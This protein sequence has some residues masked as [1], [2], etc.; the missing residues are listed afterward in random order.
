MRNIFLFRN[1]LLALLFLC[2]LIGVAQV[3]TDMDYQIM[4]TDPTTGQVLAN[5][6]MTVRV[7]LRLN[8]ENGTAVWS[9]E[10]TLTSSKAGVC[11]LS[12]NFKGVDWSLG[13]YFIK[14]FVNGEPIGASQVKSVPFAMIADAVSGV[15]TKDELVGTWKRLNDS[16]SRTFYFEEDGHFTFTREGGVKETITGVWKINNLG[17]FTFKY[18]DPWSNSDDEDVDI[19]FSVY[20]KEYNSLYLGGNDSTPFD[21]CYI[22]V[23]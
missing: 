3:P 19:L 11:T 9:K 20:E 4:A 5:K 8:S 13:K 14:A 22:K 7:E 2:P 16:D 12:L 23:K 6:E 21:A 17:Y 18:K 10:E 1:A 15:I